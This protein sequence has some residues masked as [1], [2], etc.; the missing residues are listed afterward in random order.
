MFHQSIYNKTAIISLFSMNIFWKRRFIF[1]V[2]I[3]LDVEFEVTLQIDF[4]SISI[5][6]TWRS[7][8]SWM[9]KV[10]YML[11]LFFPRSILSD[12]KDFQ[13]SSFI[14]C[15]PLSPC[16]HTQRHK[17][18]I[19]LVVLW[20]FNST[21][22]GRRKYLRTTLGKIFP[23]Y[24]LNWNALWCRGGEPKWKQCLTCATH[25]TAQLL[26]HRAVRER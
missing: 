4:S 14:I 24:F 8:S 18:F 16:L 3:W 5:T 23:K 10:S 9:K 1:S 6:A 26:W 21:S 25:F 12:L 2:L 20:K 22:P 15:V 11:N 7:A 17:G 19:S 13:T